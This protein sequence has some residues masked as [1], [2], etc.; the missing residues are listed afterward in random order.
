MRGTTVAGSGT[1]V[2]GL[3]MYALAKRIYDR[4]DRKGKGEKSE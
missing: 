3:L 2:A 4:D 1:A